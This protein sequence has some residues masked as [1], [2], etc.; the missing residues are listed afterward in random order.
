MAQNALS[1]DK[2]IWS[3]NFFPFF[4]PEKKLRSGS[5]DIKCTEFRN[6][7]KSGS[8]FSRWRFQQL[9]WSISRKVYFLSYVQVLSVWGEPRWEP[10]WRAAPEAGAVWGRRSAPQNG[11]RLEA[12]QREVGGTSNRDR[13]TDTFIQI[14]QICFFS[15]CRV[16]SASGWQN[17]PPLEV[18][19]THF[20]WIRIRIWIRFK[21]FDDQKW[22][23]TSKLQ[24]KLSA[25]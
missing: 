1:K 7:K 22:K 19:G 8:A 24:E 14:C 6:N 16:M 17:C 2:I 9:P 3:L 11:G 20:K 4:W 10:L 5:V 13:L 21:G 15:L 18:Q 25:L 12:S 23:R